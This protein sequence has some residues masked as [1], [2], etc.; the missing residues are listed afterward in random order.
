[1]LV[2]PGGARSLRAAIS[3]LFLVDNNVAVRAYDG[4]LSMVQRV[5]EIFVHCVVGVCLGDLIMCY[6]GHS[7]RSA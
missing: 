4:R 2:I 7:S 1:M 5:G 3:P 6:V